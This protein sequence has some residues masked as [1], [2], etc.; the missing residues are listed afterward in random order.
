MDLVNESNSV[1][2]RDLLS[3]FGLVNQ[4]HFPTH[5]CGH[6]LKYRK[7]NEINLDQFKQ[8]IFNSSLHLTAFESLSVS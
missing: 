3:T 7:N 8:E 4:V 6:T 2:F 5:S 1:S